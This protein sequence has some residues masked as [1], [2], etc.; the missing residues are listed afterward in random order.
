MQDSRFSPKANS[1]A[2]A[3]Q[4]AERCTAREQTHDM[5]GA[6][7]PAV[8]LM[9]EIMMSRRKMQL[10]N[11]HYIKPSLSRKLPPCVFGQ[12]NLTGNLDDILT[13]QELYHLYK[14]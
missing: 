8:Y 13:N 1:T 12:I 7:L 9:K 2:D 5:G 4:Q 11:P 6:S 3:Q 10:H 14:P